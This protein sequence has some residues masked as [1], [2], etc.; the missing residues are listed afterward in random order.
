MD[1]CERA[2]EIVADTRRTLGSAAANLDEEAQIELY[3]LAFSTAELTAAEVMLEYAAQDAP[4]DE[5]AFKQALALAFSA[6][7]ASNLHHRLRLRPSAYGLG[8]AQLPNDYVEFADAYLSPEHLSALGQAWRDRSGR[9]PDDHL[10]GEKSMIRETFRQFSDERVAPLAESIHRGNTMIPDAIID[11][12]RDLGCFG[13]CVP[14]RYGGLQ[15]DD[16]EDRLGMVVVTEELSRGSLGAAGSLITRPEIMAQALL[17]G[18]TEAQKRRWLP[19]LAAGDL[20]CAVSVTEPSTGSDV[21]AVSLRAEK[22]DGG[23]LLNGGK[24]WCTFAGKA[25]AILVLARTDPV[26]RP[27]HRGL[28]LFVVEKPSYDGHDFEYAEP[29]GGK[30][31]GRAIPTIGYRGMHSFEMFYDDFFVPDD[32]LVGESQG[33]GRGFYYTMRGF[34]GGRL[35]TAAR[36]SGLM[37]AAFEAALDYAENR[38]VFGRA[39]AGFP[40]TLQKLARMGMYIVACRQFSYAVAQRIDAAGASRNG[41]QMA[42]SLVKLFACKVAES[43]TREAMQIHGG[44]GYGEE[45]AVSRYFVDA[46]VLSI[47]EGAEETLALKVVG[48]ALLSGAHSLWVDLITE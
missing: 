15:P 28:S 36:A 10:D 23:W 12:L 7:A 38:S 48:R 34:S 13:L 35:Q 8:A 32:A 44:M 24:T 33:R 42:A 26:V 22:I 45:S 5:Q 11:G 21:A 41:A 30:V 4:R 18:G 27:A 29:R 46:R 31:S 19:A 16:S 17:E 3:D 25:G 9:L 39:V 2:R 1:R 37:R 20:L 40:L 14:E 43:V 6:E 47:F